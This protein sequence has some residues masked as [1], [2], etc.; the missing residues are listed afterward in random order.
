MAR[1]YFGDIFGEYEVAAINAHKASCLKRL[2]GRIKKRIHFKEFVVFTATY[3]EL[4]VT[5]LP[6]YVHRNKKTHRSINAK[7][8]GNFLPY[9]PSANI[10]TN[11][12]I[13]DGILLKNKHD[14]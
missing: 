3:V 5:V 1:Y 8:E 12:P 4:N 13:E 10:E 7:D 9:S 2:W 11:S 14:L 6:N